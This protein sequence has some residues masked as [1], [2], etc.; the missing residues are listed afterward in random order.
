MAD[1]PVAGSV[2]AGWRSIRDVFEEN[3]RPSGNDPGD[4]GAG[5]CVIADGAVV[6]DLVGGWRDRAGR[7]PFGH[8]TL[9]NSYSVGKGITAILA[10]IAVSRGLIDLDEPVARHWPGFPHRTTLRHH[11]THQAGL[12]ALRGNHDDDLPTDW[13]RM[14]AALA[15]TA[16]WW[17]PGTAHG[18]HV[19]TA[20]FLVGE[21]L[22][23]A[24]GATRF[25]DLLRDWVSGPLDVDMYYGVPDDALARCSEIA[26][27]G[28][29][30]PMP[31][32]E[33]VTEFADEATRMRHHAYFNPSTVSGLSIVESRRWRQAE[34]PSTNLHTTA[35]AVA[36]AYAA[37]LDPRGPVDAGLRREAATTQV[38][39]VDLILEKRSRFGLGFQLHQDDRPVGVSPSSFGHYGF[40]GSVGF[41]DPDAGLAVGYVL[42]RPGDRW[43]I[44]RTRRLLAALRARG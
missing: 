19:N 32:S 40:G 38:D 37:V 44:P 41:A 17:E 35:R 10:L 4:L 2:D 6:V 29:A 36:E 31:P 39:G 15:G 25:G 5:L 22:R 11:L 9:V 23:R 7:Y 30:T 14:C 34:V 21:P 12:P 27:T 33:P 20:G 3:L 13:E 24:T 26:F 18:Y 42:N 8:D 1:P 43:Q 16:P 28:G